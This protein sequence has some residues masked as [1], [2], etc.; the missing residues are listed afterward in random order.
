MVRLEHLLTFYSS[1]IA[2]LKTFQSIHG[3]CKVPRKGKDVALGRWVK[4]RR[5]NR[6]LL[7]RGESSVLTKRKIKLLNSI[8]FSWGYQR[9]PPQKKTITAK[10]EM[11]IEPLP[12][13]LAEAMVP[14]STEPSSRNIITPPTDAPSFRNAIQSNSVFDDAAFSSRYEESNSFVKEEVHDVSFNHHHP[15]VSRHATMSPLDDESVSF[16]RQDNT[17]PTFNFAPTQNQGYVVE[18]LPNNMFGMNPI[19]NTSNMIGSNDFPRLNSSN[20]NVMN[21]FPPMMESRL[22]Q[23][24][25]QMSMNRH[26][27][28]SRVWKCSVCRFASFDTFDEALAHE[29]N[30]NGFPEGSYCRACAA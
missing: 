8:G 7:D 24:V 26:I 20:M 13:M 30:C 23:E 4:W 16:D 15:I 19:M 25:E 18:P 14:A 2:E 27:A 28:P 22:K 12:Y 10:P 11:S 21:S 3:H 17:S 29:N 6:T 1:F 9:V 5:W